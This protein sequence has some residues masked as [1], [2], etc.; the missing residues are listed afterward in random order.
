MDLDFLEIGTSTYE[1]LIQE[2]TDTTI[3]IS[4]E[5]V[6][7]NLDLLPNKPNVIK[8]NAAITS[9]R[10]TDSVEIFYI[11][12]N[13]V[14]ESIYWLKGCNTI[15]APHPVEHGG[16]NLKYVVSE[17]VRLMNI[18]EL[19]QEYQVRSIKFLK[20]DT[21]GHDCIILNGLFD[22]LKTRP[23]TEY[24]KRIQFETNDLTD[25]TIV[26]NIIIRAK[27]FGYRVVS[28]SHD[29][30]LVYII[31]IPRLVNGRIIMT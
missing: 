14:P 21:E 4:V 1:T 18:D 12:P 24:P 2:A 15:G 5:P 20:I 11:P 29:T 31:G 9:N 16:S 30:E 7:C 23:K 27:A 26:D 3:G 22:Y 28:R 25:K 19:L 17:A 8:V 6:K 10:K 13:E